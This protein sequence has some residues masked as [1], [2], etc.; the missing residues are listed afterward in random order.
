MKT[1][2]LFE[3]PRLWE[4]NSNCLWCETVD[5]LYNIALNSQ[6]DDYNQKILDFLDDNYLVNG[7]KVLSTFEKWGLKDKISAIN[8]YNNI[9]YNNPTPNILHSRWCEWCGSRKPDILED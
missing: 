4:T 8:T 9:D 7:Y 3:N 5:I 2:I 1:I 6:D